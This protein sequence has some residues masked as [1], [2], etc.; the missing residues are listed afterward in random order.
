MQHDVLY[1]AFRQKKKK[2]LDERR[3]KCFN[4]KVNIFYILNYTDTHKAFP[5]T[6][7]INIHSK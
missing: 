5:T 2:K 6:V 4:K 1:Y 3:V 7:F